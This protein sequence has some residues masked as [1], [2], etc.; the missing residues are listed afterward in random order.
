MKIGAVVVTYNRLEKL[1]IALKAFADQECLPAYVIVVD[2]ASTDGTAQYL[3]GWQE[4][5]S[6]FRRIVVSMETN[7]GGSGG[8]YAGLKKGMELDADWIW[9]S[10]DDAY[11]QADALKIASDYLDRQQDLSGIAAICGKVLKNGILDPNHGKYY[12]RKGIRICEA[13]YPESLYEK[14]SFEKATFSYVGTIISREKMR[15]AGLTNRDY[16]IYWDDLEHGMR[17]RRTGRILCIPAIT[18]YHDVGIET[19]GINW[20]LYYSYR[21]MI[22]TYR[23]HFAGASYAFFIGKVRIKLI[24]SALTG[25]RSLRM[26]ILQAAYEDAMNQRFGLHPVYRPGWKPGENE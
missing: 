17:M 5:E 21:N 16:F 8:F 11:P 26:R 9:V 15:E 24:L 10:D 23:K 2:N 18:A 1:K 22:D 7:A 14:E 20:R 3:A 6:N 12:Y 13:V 25:H 19:D 4:E